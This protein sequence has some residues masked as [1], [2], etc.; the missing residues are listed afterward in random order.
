M[1]DTGLAETVTVRASGKIGLHPV[2]NGTV[3]GPLRANPRF[4]EAF[5]RKLKLVQDAYLSGN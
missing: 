4:Q 1:E 2:A 3:F 5:A